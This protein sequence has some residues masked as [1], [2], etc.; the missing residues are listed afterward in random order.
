MEYQLVYDLENAG[1]PSWPAV[2]LGLLFITVGV[3]FFMFRDRIPFRSRKH[4]M[5][6]AYV[7]PLFATMFTVVVATNTFHRH[8]FLLD[9]LRD[10]RAE[11]VSGSVS[12]FVPMPRGGHAMERFCVEAECFEYSDFDE[13]GGGFNNTS[14]HGGPIREDLEVRVTHVDGTIVRLE[15]AEPQP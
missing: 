9:A 6:F 3:M 10:G 1:Y 11:V 8:A 14:S 13:T 15:V 4:R 2:G 12:D 7:L 5:V